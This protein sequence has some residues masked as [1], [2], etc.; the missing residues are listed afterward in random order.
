[1]I[2]LEYFAQAKLAA[3]CEREEFEP[4][5]ITGLDQLIENSCSKHGAEL[6]S[7]L[8]NEGRLA[9]WILVSVNGVATT[10]RNH[11]LNDGDVV[12]LVSPMSGG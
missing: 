2:T 8:L 12:R 10:D 11:A 6:S 1:M 7:V 9:P 4:T 3:G 5:T